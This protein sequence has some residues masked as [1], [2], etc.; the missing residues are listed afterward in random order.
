MSS[1]LVEVIR[2]GVVESAHGGIVAVFDDSGHPVLTIGDVTQRVFPRSAVKAFQALALVESGAADRFG[3][4][5]AEL[6][7]ACSSHSGEPKHVETARGMLAAAGL[8]ETALEC[9]A[10]WPYLPEAV[11]ALARSGAAPTAAFNN[12]SGKHSGFL[13]YARHKGYAPSGYVGR[14]HPVQRDIAAVLEALLGES[15]AP[16]PCGTD[17]CSI[18]T[19]AVRLDLT[20][21]AFARF[22]TGRGMPA[23]RAA[24][25]ARLRSAC[26][27]RPDMVAGTGRFCT[28]LMSLLGPRVFAKTGAEGV[29]C[30]AIPELGLG[31][32]LK[33]SDGGTRASEAMMAAVVRRFLPVDGE[34][35]NALDAMASPEIRNWN[36]ILT[37]SVRPSAAFLAALG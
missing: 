18:P 22:G 15:L 9:G 23:E 36:G 25:A 26:A 3:Y 33:C 14:E 32:A 28:R 17:G 37:G 16:V 27:A 29:F 4:G 5:D 13:A 1:P 24:A 20:A 6:A 19:Y 12:C 31:I 10:H 21:A 35:A 30:G 11:H 34:T 8:D 2:G 7:L